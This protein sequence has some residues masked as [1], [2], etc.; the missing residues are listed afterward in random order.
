MAPPLF[1]L[2]MFANRG[3][4]RRNC[5]QRKEF[6][7]ERQMKFLTRGAFAAP[8]GAVSRA[9]AT[10]LAYVITGAM[11]LR[12]E[13]QFHLHHRDNESVNTKHVSNFFFAVAISA[14]NFHQLI[15]ITERRKWT[16]EHYRTI[17]ERTAMITIASPSRWLWGW[18][19]GIVQFR[20]AKALCIS[21]NFKRTV[22]MDSFLFKQGSI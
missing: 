9:F 19:R 15:S 22:M 4:L 2:T 11:R 18:R 3:C 14:A 17:I 5:V 8:N 7:R 1:H 16:T 20:T 10:R 13:T 6:G 12:T 21:W